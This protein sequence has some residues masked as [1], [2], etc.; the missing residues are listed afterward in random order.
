MLVLSR[1]KGESLIIG[2]DIKIK[3]QECDNDRV[4]IGID[5]PK[6][7]PLYA[8]N[9]YEDTAKSNIEAISSMFSLG[10]L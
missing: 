10:D 4:S 9:C 5:A 7:S 2:D 3:I 8:V 1:K 6:K